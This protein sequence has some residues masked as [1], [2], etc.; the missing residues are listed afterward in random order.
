VFAKEVG[1]WIPPGIQA[2]IDS[3]M[4]KLLNYMDETMAAL[5]ARPTINVAAPNVNVAPAAAPI[6]MVDGEEIALRIVTP[7]RVAK[8]NVEGQRRRNF[9]NTGRP[10]AA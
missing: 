10:A 6:L 8:A 1:A 4:P 2:G 7:D 3:G 9:L 5:S